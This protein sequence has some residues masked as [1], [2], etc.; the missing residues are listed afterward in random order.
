MEVVQ[1]QPRD[2]YLHYVYV[3]AKGMTIRWSFTTKRKNIAFGLF[4]RLGTARLQSSSDIVF[5]QLQ[6]QRQLSLPSVDGHEPSDDDK[7]AVESL[8][9]G[10][11]R[12]RPRAKSTASNKLREQE[13]F[14]EVIPIDHCNSA[15]IKVEGSYVVHQ[16]GNFV[17]VFDNTFSKTT[18]KSLTF[19][20]TVVGT[21]DDTLNQRKEVSG[22]IL[23]K[24]RKK[25]QGW[26]KRWLQLSPTG[27]LSYSTT[28]NSITRGSIQIVMATTSLNP[29]QRLIHID[30]G[31]ML[32]HLKALTAE[33]YDMWTKTLRE[34]R[35][36]GQ[37]PQQTQ[38]SITSEEA[39]SEVE[40]GVRGSTALTASVSQYIRNADMMKDLL[41]E[42]GKRSGLE[43]VQ[44]RLAEL[45]VQLN[46][47]K[48]DVVQ[49]AEEQHR[50][51]HTVQDMLHTVLQGEP[52]SRTAGVR[53]AEDLETADHVTSERRASVRASVF[54]EQF[55]DA[56]E[57]LLSGD[58]DDDEDYCGSVSA[59][60][61]D[62]DEEEAKFK[63]RESLDLTRLGECNQRR[64]SLPSPSSADPAY[65]SIFRKNVGKDLS[66]ISM[67]INMNE[68]LNLLQKSCEE[69]E[70]S[71]LLDKASSS[72]DSM[73]RLMYVAV[74]AISGYGS[75][76]YRTGRKEF[77]T[78]G[79]YHITLSGHDDHYTYTK[80]SSWAR[81]MI[82]GEKY[83][84]HVGEMKVINHTT[85][86]YGIVTFKEGKGGGLFS[87][88]TKRNEVVASFHDANGTRRKRVIGTWSEGMSEEV[89]LNS[90]Q[91]SILWRSQAPGIEDYQRHYGFTRFCVEMNEI[92]PIEKGKL[93]KTD[94]RLRPDQRLYEN[95]QTDEAEELKQGI[96]Q[97][98]R[99]RR[100][101]MD[102]TGIEWKPRWFALK[103]DDHASP[104][105]NSEDEVAGQTW[106][107]SGH[108]W[109]TRESGQWPE[110]IFDLW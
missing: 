80:P 56:Q 92:T 45:A 43:D 98:Q 40:Q 102:E 10:H 88:P 71:E 20:V 68:P 69:L 6:Q 29:Q 22:W 67:P 25:L 79:A 58:E 86:E 4:Q 42:L 8:S 99:D 66:Q 83:L 87:A 96:E 11:R 110:D 90:E 7:P 51:W 89:D 44:D 85:G 103:Q 30:S 81:N 38:T 100:R 77:I 5:P 13:D 36:D 54:S 75:S 74:F 23:K 101:E 108:Y 57:I 27:V 63:I 64:K 55:F 37:Q 46:K 2:S 31:T 16:P 62:E 59:E 61:E 28:P 109:P 104:S 47:D 35:N 105:L 60:S 14:V 53:F 72:F 107:Y 78:E 24:R 12:R 41:C 26:A 32:Y 94:T 39:W 1:V 34:F 106:Q 73:E 95:G 76:Q 15:D 84:E 19:S 48:G 33:D 18:P 3:P 97:R 9:S 93:P 52:L 82:A 49:A 70:Y 91:L 50:R 21:K 65:L 17:L